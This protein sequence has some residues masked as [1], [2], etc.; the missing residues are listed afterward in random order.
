MRDF[1]AL[2][3][4]GDD[5]QHLAAMRDDGIGDDPHETDLAAAVHKAHAGPGQAAA[6]IGACVAV[7]RQAAVAGAAEHSNG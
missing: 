4:L 6:E 2:Q 3:E 7:G 1:A 5:A